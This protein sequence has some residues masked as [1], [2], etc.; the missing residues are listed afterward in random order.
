MFIIVM[1]MMTGGCLW[2][3]CLLFYTSFLAS[4]SIIVFINI[5]A[6]CC[7][8]FGSLFIIIIIII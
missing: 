5:I 2:L 8:T 1:M 4:V 6:G 3:D 7:G